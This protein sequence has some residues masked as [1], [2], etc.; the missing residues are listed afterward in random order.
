M[1][2]FANGCQASKPRERGDA[3]VGGS[4]RLR[5][6]TSNA[7][8]DAIASRREA[9]FQRP[10]GVNSQ[11][12]QKPDALVCEWLRRYKAQLVAGK[13]CLARRLRRRFFWNTSLQI[14][15]PTLPVEKPSFAGLLNAL[16]TGETSRAR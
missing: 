9:I 3:S 16:A 5:N 8:T 14:R 4:G 11:R 13:R 1:R 15:V 7:L 10:D 2:F 12:S 6:E